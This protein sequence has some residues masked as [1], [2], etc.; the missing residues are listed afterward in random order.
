MTAG[1]AVWGVSY[2]GMNALA[3]AAHRPPH[4]RALVAVYA[5]T[6]MYR[7]TIAPGVCPAMLGRYAWAAHML[8]LA[9]CPRPGRTRTAGGERTWQRRLRRLAVGH[10]PHPGLAGAPGAG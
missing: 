3:A 4:L 8:A 10:P 7:D 5:T 2:G 6:D 9:L 1:L